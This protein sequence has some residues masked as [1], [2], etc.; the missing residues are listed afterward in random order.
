MKNFLKK[1]IP[2]VLTIV[3]LTIPFSAPAFAAGDDNASSNG[4]VYLLGMVAWDCNTGLTDGTEMNEDQ[5]KSGIVAAAANILTDLTVISAYLVIG[6]VIYG[7]YL[8]TFS[9]G[10]PG[11]VATGRKALSQAFIGLAIVMSANVILNSIRIALGANFTADCTANEAG[12]YNAVSASNMVVQLIGW[13]IAIA[14]IV[15]AIFVVY[16][17]ISYMT[18]SGDPGKLKKAK[19]MITYALIGLAIVALAEIITAFVSSMIRDAN[20]TG[21]INNTTIA[22]EL[23]EKN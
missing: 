23:Y 11:K 22:K 6:Y 19:D 16:G 5:L 21:Y 7:G 1:L 9:G 13:V 20:D 15:S 17:G 12:C 2:L 8:Y 3:F 4:C 14:G 10:D 18:S